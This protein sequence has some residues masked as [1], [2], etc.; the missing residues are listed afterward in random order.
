MD[1]RV[2]PL[3]D[4]RMPDLDA[5]M[6]Q[7]RLRIHAMARGERI[8][9][10]FEDGREW[11]YGEFRQRVVRAAA[12]LHAMGIRQD[13]HVVM[14][15]PNGPE[16]LVLWFAVNHLGAVFVPLNTAYKGRVLHS[17]LGIA[18]GA[19]LVAHRGLVGRLD[20]APALPPRLVALGSEGEAQPAGWHP[21]SDIFA[22]GGEAP[23]PGRDIMPRDT[24]SID[25]TSGTTGPSK[26]S[27]QSYFQQYTIAVGAGFL[28]AED[29]YLM[30]LPLYHQ[31]GI[32]GVNRMFV[33]G[34]SH[35]D[36]GPLQHEHHLA[37]R[38]APDRRARP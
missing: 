12:G 10:R 21:A 29:R 37:D 24:Q 22:A 11:S 28:T 23:P 31:G 34:G 5:V 7:R 26:A 4:P 6:P 13:D 19:M 3:L 2:P 27:A 20:T 35:R 17:V 25:I 14:W 30:T 38:G 18:E 36:G 8:F 33:C 9:V 32:T 1:A 15:L 16:A